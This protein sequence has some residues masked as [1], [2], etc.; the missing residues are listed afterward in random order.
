MH[1]R[2]Q[3]IWKFRKAVSVQYGSEV[4]QTCNLTVLVHC[5]SFTSGAEE[6][7]FPVGSKFKS[8][9]FKIIPLQELDPGFFPKC[10][11]TQVG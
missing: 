7:H 1:S 5:T 10:L 11:L 6:F 3:A 4:L 2:L 9:L 8:I